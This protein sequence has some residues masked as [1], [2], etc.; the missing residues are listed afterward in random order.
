MLKMCDIVQR[1]WR[2]LATDC[3]ACCMAFISNDLLACNDAG[4]LDL[5]AC[6][7]TKYSH[8]AKCNREFEKN[9]KAYNTCIYAT[10]RIPQPQR[11]CSCHR[12]RVYVQ[13]IEFRLPAPTDWPTTSRPVLTCDM[14]RAVA[15][16][17]IQTCLDFANSVLIGTSSSNIY[18]LQRIQN[19]LAK[20]T[21]LARQFWIR[22]S[23]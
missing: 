17:F 7:Y 20:V 9:A 16:S 23:L 8:K 19:C 4:T 14:A 12:Q 10:S 13:S 2:A 21:T 18:K 22:W 15:A 11:R 5:Q 3:S 1:C 6:A